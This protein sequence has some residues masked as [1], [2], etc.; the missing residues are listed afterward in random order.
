MKPIDPSELKETF[1][2]LNSLIEN[3]TEQL[4]LIETL[5]E[6]IENENKKIVIKTSN[7]THFIKLNELIR[8]EADGAYTDFI[9]ETNKIISSKNIKFYE[10]LLDE[11]FIRCHQSHIV[12]SRKIISIDKN[13]FLL[14]SNDE[15]VPVSSR[16]KSATLQLIKE[17]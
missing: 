11:T 15:K 8:L 7:Y 10:E 16:K 12:N 3:E 4:N 13:D 17:L 14:M 1:E 6:N 2:K 9:T 5:K